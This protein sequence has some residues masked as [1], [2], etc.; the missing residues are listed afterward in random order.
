ME[1]LLP[2]VLKKLWGKVEDGR[3]SADEFGRMQDS[4]VKSIRMAIETGEFAPDTD[5]EQMA[6][7]LFGILASCYRSRNLFH[8]Q[9]A[10]VRAR[11]AF[12]RLFKSALNPGNP[13]LP[14][15]PAASADASLPPR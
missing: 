11:R 2:D 12:D 6:F 9:Q 15:A 7:E 13:V 4:L 5:A 1:D 10:N 3:L 8:D 14:P